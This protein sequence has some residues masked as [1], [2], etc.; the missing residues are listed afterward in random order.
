[1]ELLIFLLSYWEFYVFEIPYITGA[2]LIYRMLGQKNFKSDGKLLAVGVVFWVVFLL[3]FLV[4]AFG[5]LIFIM[6][7]HA[8]KV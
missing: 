3:G 6:F 7:R 4:V 8:E 2:F 1:M 5:T